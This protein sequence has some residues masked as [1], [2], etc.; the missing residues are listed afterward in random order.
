MVKKHFFSAHN[1]LKTGFF[2]RFSLIVGC[3]I[4]IIYLVE[5][6]LHPF[7]FNDDTIGALLAFA[8]LFLG[9]GL[10]LYF[11]SCQFAKLS[12]IAQEVE[13]DASL[14]DKEETKEQ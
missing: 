12:K 6:L 1:D 7:G 3:I 5:T 8:I 2:C 9:L 13:N 14:M 11:F 4:F 10:I